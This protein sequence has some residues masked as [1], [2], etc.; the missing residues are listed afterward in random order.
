MMTF[1]GL[2]GIDCP[3]FSVLGILNGTIDFWLGGDL[4]METAAV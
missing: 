3:P 1:V 2:A 4:I